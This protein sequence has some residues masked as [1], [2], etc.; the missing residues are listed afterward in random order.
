[1]QIVIP[2]SGFGERFRQAG[3]TVPKP[4]IEVDGKPIIQYIVEMFSDKDD[5]IFICNEDH[6]NNKTYGMESI[7][8]SICSSCVI[9]GILPHKLGPVHAVMQ[10]IDF[11]NLNSSVIVNYC[12]FTCDWD[13][14]DFSNMVG[15][16]ECD[17][18]IPCYRGFH[19]H[20]LWS[21]YY[22]YV[23]EEKMHAYNIQE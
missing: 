18:A 10:S 3:Y 5:F 12:D 1:M 14:S 11:I 13:Y 19:P 4:L 2:M 16:T 6:L 22:A 20:T 8:R 23:Q 17:G 9:V 21:N 15:E 7:L